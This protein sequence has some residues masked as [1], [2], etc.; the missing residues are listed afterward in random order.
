L[1]P[2]N[3]PDLDAFWKANTFSCSKGLIFVL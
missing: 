2:T 3:L 1:K